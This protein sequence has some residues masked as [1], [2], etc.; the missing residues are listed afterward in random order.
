MTSKT[1]KILLASSVILLLAFMPIL[2][3]IPVAMAT[4]AS[5]GIIEPLY[6]YPYTGSTFNWL[7]VNQTKQNHPNVPFFATVNPDSGPCDLAAGQ[8]Q[9]DSNYERGIANLTKSGT[10]VLGY[11][12][13]IWFDYGSGSGG[14]C[15]CNKTQ[16]TLSQV[17]NEIDT[18]NNFYGASKLGN[19]GIKG[20]MF[21]DMQNKDANGGVS[22]NLTYY[23]TL[24]NYVHN[25]GLTYSYANPGT[26]V[27][28]SYVG[29]TA[30]SLNIFEGSGGVGVP[31]TSTLQTNTLVND[32]G[33]NDGF[34]KHNFSFVVYCQTLLPGKDFIGNSSNFVGLMYFTGA[35]CSNTNPWNTIASYLSTLASDLDHP[36]A[37]ININSV[38]SVGSPISGYF[39]EVDQNSNAI[40]SGYTPLPYNGTTGVRYTFIPNGFNGCNFDHWQDTGSTTASRSILV[41]S[42]SAT[43]TAVYSGTC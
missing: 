5:T 9:I 19:L 3:A 42:T 22:G 18:W 15:P 30:D 8:C 14:G 39:V 36:T 21:D 2:Q 23:Q 10:V 24:E 6:S 20:I 33:N 38:N 43:F 17:E 11:V 25:A 40:P 26:S 7:A 37:L 16:K 4:S 41:N 35:G 12:D 28:Q 34:D 1:S 32:G 27:D 29:A 31:S 13:T